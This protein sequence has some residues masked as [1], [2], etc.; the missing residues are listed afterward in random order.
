MGC[1]FR[2][3]APQKLRF[4]VAAS[5]DVSADF[6]GRAAA[7]VIRLGA[8]GRQMDFHCRTHR[9]LPPGSDKATSIFRV[10]GES[11]DLV[12]DPASVP[13]KV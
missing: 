5:E 4:I 7:S 2:R 3:G 8:V 11:K 13:A 12:I 10:E 1:R 6:I 9:R